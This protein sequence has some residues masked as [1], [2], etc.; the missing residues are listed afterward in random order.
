MGY[1]TDIDHQVQALLKTKDVLALTECYK[2]IQPFARA[3]L[4]VAE[5]PPVGDRAG[6]AAIALSPKAQGMV[7]SSGSKGSRLC[8]VRLKGAFNNLFIVSAYIPHKHRHQSPFQED[9]LGELQVLINTLSC[10]GDCVIVMGDMNAKIQ[11]S[12]KGVSGR[13]SMHAKADSGGERLTEIMQ[14]TNLVA[15]ATFFCP[16]RKAP[17]GNATYRPVNKSHNPS[18]IDH[19]LISQKWL[20]SCCKCKVQWAPAIT[21]HLEPMDHGLLTL[22]L[23]FR[24]IGKRPVRKCGVDRAWLADKEN[25]QVFDKA[26]CKERE[27]YSPEG[28]DDSYAKISGYMRSALKSVPVVTRQKKKGRASSKRTIDLITACA[29]VLQGSKEGTAEHKARKALFRKAIRSSCRDD[30]REHVSGVIEEMENCDDRGD[31]RGVQEGVNLLSGKKKAFSS[32]QPTFDQ[33]GKPIALPEELA[34]AWGKFCAEKF[35]CTKAEESRPTAPPLS[36][37]RARESDVPTD[38][39]LWFCLNAL[40]KQKAT[41]HDDVPI[42]AYRASVQASADLFALI[43][44][45]WRLEDV[46]SDLVLTSL[47]TI[48]KKGDSDDY[49]KYRCIGLLPHAYKVLSTLL[50]KRMLEEVDWFLPESQAGFR[51]LRS[52][53]DN[54]Y[55]LARLMDSVLESQETCVVT[56]IDFVAAFDSVSHRFLESALFEAGASDKSRAIFKAIYSKAAAQIRVTTAAGEQVFSQKFQVDRGVIQ[57][58]I[59]SPLCFIVALE[60]IMRK[61]GGKGTVTAFGVLI[62]RL[63]YADDAALIDRDSVLAAQRVTRLCAGGLADAD[64]DISA[65]K[66]KVLF[67][68]PRIDTGPI[69]PEDYTDAALKELDLKF[70]HRCPHCDRGFDSV[71]GCNGH[72]AQHCELARVQYHAEEFEVEVIDARGSPDRRFYLAAWKG[73]SADTASWKHE[74]SMGHAKAAVKEYWKYSAQGKA[75]TIEA[76]GENRCP[77]CCGFYKRPADLKGHFTRGCPMVG[78]S[79]VGSRAEKFV[80]KGRQVQLQ[81]AAGVVMMGDRRLQNVFN[82]PYLGFNF[83]ADGDRRPAMDQRM[84]IAKSRFGTLHEVW[85]DKKLPTSAK[86]RIYACAVVSVLTYGNEI[87]RMDA[88]TQASLRGWNARCLAAMTGRSFRDETVDPTFDLLSRL[89]SRRLRW[90]GHILRQEESSLMRRVLL[91]SVELGLE[92]PEAGGI[93]MDAPGFAS[94]EQLLLMA[95]DREEWRAAVRALLP[96]SDPSTKK[97]CRSEDKGKESSCGFDKDGKLAQ[98]F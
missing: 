26:Y 12:L 5:T 47:I 7:I 36:P 22:S 71:H 59:F 13:F 80:A 15:V 61:H 66:S 14:A 69:L 70:E 74:R 84:A 29:S 20:G 92:G 40:A 48:Y 18:Q 9:T 86:V 81:E 46:P 72:I 83:Q 78:G 57:G 87:W 10:K 63:E 97:K 95:G 32:K 8:W 53:R 44:A 33:E 55:L 77:D 39:E 38:E 11:R 49:T 41:G 98:V 25:H 43:R 28:L 45:I 96:E 89:R 16:P 23:K 21:R 31:R 24:V 65:P 37:A 82:F 90:A 54:I 42:E 52:T 85:R 60:S 3:G 6:A 50:L 30:Y 27:G 17:L 73:Y 35:A 93:L 34:K 94:E 91:A 4:L 64:M 51:K 62:D 79:R 58:D 75:D 2:S 56:F 88:K 68:R 76:D 19:I 1:S 67:C